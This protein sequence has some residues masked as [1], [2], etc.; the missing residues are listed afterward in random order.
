M[1]RGIVGVVVALG[2]GCG[3]PTAQAAPPREARLDPAIAESS[4]LVASRTWP[5]VFWTLSDSGNAAELFAVDADG[6]LLR[7]VPVQGADNIDWEE[8]ALDDDGHLWIADIGNNDDLRRDL[9]VHRV[10]EP[11]PTGT[12]PAVVERTVAVVYPEQTAWPDPTGRRFDAEALFWG[13]GTLWLLTK[14]RAD[15]STTLYRFGSLEGESKLDKVGALALGGDPKRYG[16]LATAADLH[17]SG[18]WLALLT[19]HALIVFERPADGRSWLSH[20]VHRV[21]LDQD[22]TVQCEGVAW[23]GWSVLLTNEDRRIFRIADPF[24][25]DRFPDRAPGAGGR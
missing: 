8:L 13:D 9:A 1:H 19:Y 18:R 15:R 11:D 10:A 7:R 2:M 16:G 14:Q 6:R 23:D 25:T 22:V 5:G 24:R 4:A 17:P 21:A 20:E 3:G 12:A